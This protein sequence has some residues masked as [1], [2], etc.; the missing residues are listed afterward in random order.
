VDHVVASCIIRKQISLDIRWL[1]ADF[2]GKWCPHTAMA[3]PVG[4]EPKH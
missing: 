2:F 4:D 1:T 3:P